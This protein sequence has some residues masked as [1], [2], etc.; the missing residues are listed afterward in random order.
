MSVCKRS[1]KGLCNMP[2]TTNTS[3]KT[4]ISQTIKEDGMEQ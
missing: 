1:H 2:I 3:N 4:T